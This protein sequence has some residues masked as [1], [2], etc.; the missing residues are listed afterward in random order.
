MS[1]KNCAAELKLETIIVNLMRLPLKDCRIKRPGKLCVRWKWW[2]AVLVYAVSFKR[3]L[4]NEGTAWHENEV[5]AS[6]SPNF[7]RCGLITWDQA[8]KMS[9]IHWGL[10]LGYSFPFPHIDI[11]VGFS[12][13]WRSV[14]GF[15]DV[16]W[17]VNQLLRMRSDGNDG[18]ERK[19]VTERRWSVCMGICQSP[20]IVTQFFPIV[21]DGQTGVHFNSL[22]TEMDE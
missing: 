4:A 13:F 17:H 12:C 22:K 21:Q 3:K 2:F 20:K 5:L 11:F 16:L 9:S 6:S 8:K 10:L 1:L 15:M 19:Y 14:R 18:R 7:N